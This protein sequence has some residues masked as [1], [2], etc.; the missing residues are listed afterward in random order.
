MRRTLVLGVSGLLVLAACSSSSDDG[1]GGGGGTTVSVT[2]SNT[3]C[4]L[5]TKAL[6]AGDHTFEVRNTGSVA[7]EVDVYGPFDKLVAEKKDI[8]PGSTA[9]FDAELTKGY[10]QLACKPGQTGNGIREALTVL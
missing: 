7:T 6:P 4:L 3:Q 9:S 2:A 5:S 8:G 1:G 10:Y